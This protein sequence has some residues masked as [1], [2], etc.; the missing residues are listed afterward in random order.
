ME[1]CFFRLVNAAFIPHCQLPA[2]AIEAF[3]SCKTFSLCERSDGVERD[4]VVE[5]Q[6]GLGNRAVWFSVCGGQL[7]PFL[8]ERL[9]FLEA[10]EG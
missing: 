10:E 2:R 9:D 7:V 3:S 6:V 5:H 8:K 1:D 4:E